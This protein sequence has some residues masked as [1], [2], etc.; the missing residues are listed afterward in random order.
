MVAPK[1]LKKSATD[2]AGSNLC[3]WTWR[4]SQTTYVLT[5][6]AS[7][8]VARESNVP[9]PTNRAIGRYRNGEKINIRKQAHASLIDVEFRMVANQ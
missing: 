6:L 3:A 7:V 5:Y 9:R 1:R 2:P 8:A 4:Q